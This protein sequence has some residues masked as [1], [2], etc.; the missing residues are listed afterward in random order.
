M[1]FHRFSL[2]SWAHSLVSATPGT[3]LYVLEVLAGGQAAADQQLALGPQGHRARQDQLLGAMASQ[4]HQPRTVR[5][6]KPLRQPLA[7][8]EAPLERLGHA[9]R[10]GNSAHLI[11][12]HTEPGHGAM[13]LK[14][15][16]ASCLMGL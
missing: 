4:Q 9:W 15:H 12:H 3:V 14:I 8:S 2:Q 11:F 16:E 5:G 10:L 13:A 7:H 6:A 1:D